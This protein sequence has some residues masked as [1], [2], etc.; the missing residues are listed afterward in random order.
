MEFLYR[1]EVGRVHGVRFVET[2]NA[3]V[4]RGSSNALAVSEAD[5]YPEAGR[6]AVGYGTVIFGRGFYG[7][8]ELDGG[9][10]TYT[11]TGPTKEDPLNQADTYGYPLTDHIKSP[12]IDLDAAMQTGRKRDKKISHRERLNEETHYLGCDSPNFREMNLKKLVEI[13]SSL[14]TQNRVYTA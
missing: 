14:T 6:S 11:V 8:T 12:L 3:P 2:T 9:I 10:K 7:A 4:T 5:A 13:A 1:G